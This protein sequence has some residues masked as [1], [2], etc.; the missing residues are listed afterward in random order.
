MASLTMHDLVFL[1]D[2]DNTL[3][4]HDELK[5]RI[6]NILNE[7]APRHGSEVFWQLYEE[8]RE[9]TGIVS[10][11]ETARRYGVACGSRLIGADVEQ[12][13][14]D[15]PFADLVY[16][17]AAE[18]LAHLSTMGLPILLCDGDV[19]FQLHKLKMAGLAGHFGKRGFVFDHKEAHIDEVEQAFPARH[20]VMVDDKPR[21]HAAMRAAL[22]NRVT[23][24][25]VRQGGYGHS[26][27]PGVYDYLDLAVEAL[28]ELLSLTASH[29]GAVASVGPH[30]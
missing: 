21:I 27:A 11:P 19:E 8:V 25:F 9:E 26:V 12:R 14:W 24:V 20:Y 29:F 3:V 5:V 7:C 16:P 15:F 10:L 30:G 23:T 4:D 18:V 13:L 6:S 17:R 22:G 1:I 28:P 2:L